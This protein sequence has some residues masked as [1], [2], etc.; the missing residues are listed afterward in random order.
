MG[1]RRVPDLRRRPARR[2]PRRRFVLLCEG[3]STEPAYFAALR[4]ACAGNA[5]IVVEIVPK[6]GVPYTIAEAA[7]ARARELGLSGR[8][9][10]ALDSFEEG[11]EVWAVFDR[12]AH[13]R[14]AEAVRLCEDKGV[15]VA[16]SNPCFEVWL[17][18]HE[19]D[20]DRPDDRHRVQAH[21]RT[22]RPEYEPAGG[23]LPDC[24]ALMARIE[25]AEARAERQ[26]ARREEQ[27]A[28][29]GPPSTTVGRLTRAVRAAARQAQRRPPPHARSG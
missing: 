11:D 26:L 29:F 21:L 5:L 10:R 13:P 23:K 4:R 17:I 20:Y 16:R 8:R 1:R 28:P 22:L 15:R 6:V 12:D 7:V 27:G 24:A 19:A 14:Y 9:R 25:A 2:E 3:A 18:L